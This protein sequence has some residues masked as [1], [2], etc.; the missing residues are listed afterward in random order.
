ML[1]TIIVILVLIIILMFFVIGGLFSNSDKLEDVMSFVEFVLNECPD[2]FNGFVH[3]TMAH[4]DFNSIAIQYCL[5]FIKKAMQDKLEEYA[6]SENYEDAK[7]CQMYLTQ[8][9]QLIR[10]NFT[11]QNPN[12]NDN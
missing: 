1:I 11:T 4:N 3:H 10:H 6:R 5:I 8:I 2:K 12:S 7:E 9:E